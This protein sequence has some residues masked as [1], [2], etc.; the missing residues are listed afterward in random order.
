MSVHQMLFMY[1]H[2]VQDVGLHNFMPF[3]LIYKTP[4]PFTIWSLQLSWGVTLVSMTFAL[5][6][7]NPVRLITS[8][9]YGTR[10]SSDNEVMKREV[11]DVSLLHPEATSEELSIVMIT[12]S[13]N[14]PKGTLRNHRKAQYQCITTKS[15]LMD[16]PI[17]CFTGKNLA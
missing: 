11:I 4:A 12:Q 14:R 13:V 2:S 3:V 15:T 6:T 10:L 7:F 9:L 17:C 8:P 16:Q 5:I 1:V